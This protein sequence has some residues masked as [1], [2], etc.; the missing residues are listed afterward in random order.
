MLAVNLISSVI[1]SV[2]STEKGQ[3]ILN[4]MDV[5][6]VSHLPVVDENRYL[7]LISDKFIYD[8]NLLKKSIDKETDKL[9]TTHVHEDQ[10]IFEVASMMYKLKLSVMPVLKSGHDYL[11]SITLYDLARRFARYFSL[12]EVGGVIVLEVNVN[13]YSMTQIS[14]IVENND[15][16][17]LSFFMNRIPGTNRLEIIIKLDKEDLSPVIQAFN[18]YDYNIKG[19]YL[20][21][22]MLN[23]LYMDRYQQFMKYMNI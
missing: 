15:T 23:D 1:P 21:H 19:I 20:D 8:L 2:R 11:G 12:Q 16:R 3:K 22:S 10:H 13:D 6:R 4:T 18:R 17:I 5:F 7:G 9:I 14:Q